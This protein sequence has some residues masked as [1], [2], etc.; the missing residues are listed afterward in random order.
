MPGS[1]TKPC[2]HLRVPKAFLV[3]QIMFCFVCLFVLRCDFEGVVRKLGLRR[4]QQSPKRL[5]NSAIKIL[6]SVTCHSGPGWTALREQMA[7]CVLTPR[8]I[9]TKVGT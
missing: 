1:Q 9:K 8:S 2:L 6:S 4:K 3:S 5:T 7:V